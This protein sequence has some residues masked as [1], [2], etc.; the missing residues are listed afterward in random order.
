MLTVHEVKPQLGL[1]FGWWQKLMGICALWHWDVGN[2]AGHGP[3]S[4]ASTGCD[5]LDAKPV[6]GAVQRGGS[7]EHCRNHVQ[8]VFV[9]TQ[10]WCSL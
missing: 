3:M 5:W 8:Y 4:P 6:F 9:L 2:G 7:Q 1:E 10:G